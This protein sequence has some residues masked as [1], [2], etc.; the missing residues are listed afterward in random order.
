MKKLLLLL[1]TLFLFL[2]CTEEKPKQIL[3]GEELLIQKCAS[4]HN[5]D[6]PPKS[7][8]NEIAPSMMAVSFHLK[9]FIKSDN[10][11]EHEGKIIA[12]VQDYVIEPSVEKSLC[13]EESLKSYGLM[14]S[15]KGKVSNDEIE[16]I[17]HHMYEHYDNQILLQK[18][19]ETNRL[20]ALSLHERVIEEQ[21]CSNCH[22]VEKDKI[23]P[24][25]KMIAQRYNVEDK[26]ALMHSIKEGSK[27]K[28]EDKKLPMPPYKKMNDKDVEE[29][30]DWI[31]SL[32]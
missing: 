25:F 8:K 1:F 17:V 24:S 6:M 13:D 2:G 26:E 5:L 27:G 32:K 29:M 16:A 19:A 20:N 3:D 30:V 4:C 23:A 14:P 12:F 11:A 21:R 22:D 31:L 28:W 9:D 15:Q 18:M 7:Y 10:P